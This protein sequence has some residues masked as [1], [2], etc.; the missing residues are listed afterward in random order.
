M[1]SSVNPR[2]KGRDD[3][4]DDSFPHFNL[5]IFL[6]VVD[7]LFFPSQDSR[8]LNLFSILSLQL[9]KIENMIKMLH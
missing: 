5:F 4:Y 9:K 7:I 8:T 3:V 2:G 6:F 1:S